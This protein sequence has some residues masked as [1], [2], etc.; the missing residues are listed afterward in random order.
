MH[1]LDCLDLMAISLEVVAVEPRTLQAADLLLIRVALH[2]FPTDLFLAHS[3]PSTDGISSLKIPNRLVVL[4]AANDICS[5]VRAE[6][7]LKMH[8]ILTSTPGK[9]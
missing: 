9:K 4:F 8:S 3:I 2:E 6:I 1:V 7:A 5:V